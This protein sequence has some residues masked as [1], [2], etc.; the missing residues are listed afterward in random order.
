MALWL[1]EYELGGPSEARSE[2]QAAVL[3]NIK[4]AA[5]EKISYKFTQTNL[6]GMAESQHTQ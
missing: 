1:F 4:P 2:D 3:L 5:T 6:F